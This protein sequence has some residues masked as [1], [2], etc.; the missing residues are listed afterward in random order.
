MEKIMKLKCNNKVYMFLVALLASIVCI[1]SMAE[2]A[3]EPLPALTLISNVNIFDGKSDKLQEN[4]NVLIKDN[5]IETISSEPLAVTQT[6][7]V[8]MID[9]GGRTM[10]PGFIAMHEHIV[11]QMPFTDIFTQDTRYFA[12]VATQTANTYLTH[13]FTTIRDAGGNTFSLKKAIDR[14]Y[15]VGPRIYPSGPIISHSGARR[16]PAA[17][18][19]SGIHG[20]ERHMGSD[21]AIRR[22]GGRGWG[23]RGA[24]GSPGGVAHGRLADQDRCGRRHRFLRRSSGSDRVHSGGD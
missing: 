1:P 19:C 13:G 23:A 11:G 2:E 22:Y 4:M 24:Q 15:V 16:P 12:Y 20:R 14:G 21:G 8:T 9:G 5:K 3:D 17:I 18:G 7:N 10:T 6:D